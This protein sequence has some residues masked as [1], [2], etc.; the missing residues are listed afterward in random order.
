MK[1]TQQKQLWCEAVR[2][3]VPEFE[4]LGGVHS[5]RIGESRLDAKPTELTE[6]AEAVAGV[7]VHSRNDSTEIGEATKNVLCTDGEETAD[8]ALVSTSEGENG[9]NFRTSE[10]A[11]TVAHALAA[12]PDMETAVGIGVTAGVT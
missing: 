11:G 9:R 7:A 4:E 5:E 12:D 2:D 1:Q 6:E 10:T 3:T 8:S